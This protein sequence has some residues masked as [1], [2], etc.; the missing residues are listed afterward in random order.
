MARFVTVSER[1]WITTIERIFVRNVDEE[2]TVPHALKRLVEFGRRVPS[3][4]AKSGEVILLGDSAI[5]QPLGRAHFASLTVIAC[6]HPDWHILKR[7]L[8][9]HLFYLV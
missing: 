6:K 1:R 3:P 8:Y 7:L 5:M 2:M 4:K 9:G